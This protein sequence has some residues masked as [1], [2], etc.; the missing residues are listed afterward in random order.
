MNEEG[1]IFVLQIRIS[2]YWKIELSRPNAD[3]Q[4]RARQFRDTLDKI[5][6]FEK[7]PCPLRLPYSGALSADVK[8]LR[9]ALVSP[10]YTSRIK[11][12]DRDLSS[13]SSTLLADADVPMSRRASFTAEQSHEVHEAG[14]SNTGSQP[15]LRYFLGG[16]GIRHFSA[17]SSTTNVNSSGS[18]DSDSPFICTGVQKLSSSS[19]YY[20]SVPDQQPENAV[21]RVRVIKDQAIPTTSELQSTVSTPVVTTALN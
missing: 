6:L 17:I 15:R 8:H 4:D 19:D 13:T 2:Q 7:T 5:L 10:T 16:R 14:G 20:S 21:R 11:A 9:P 3:E 1:S 12:V 18:L